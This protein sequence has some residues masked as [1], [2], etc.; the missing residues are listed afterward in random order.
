MH[1]RNARL[2]AHA[3]LQ[4]AVIQDG[5]VFLHPLDQVVPLRPR[6]EH[7]GGQ[8]LGVGDEQVVGLQGGGMQ[9]GGVLQQEQQELKAEDGKEAGP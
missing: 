1:V 2:F 8:P 4:V 5:K 9:H 6:L 7:L 3:P